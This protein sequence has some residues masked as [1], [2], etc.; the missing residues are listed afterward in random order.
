M[1]GGA[2][3]PASDIPGGERP[4]DGPRRGTTVDDVR[5]HNLSTVLGIVHRDGPTSRSRLTRIIGLNRSTI[6]AL[7][8]ELVELGLVHEAQPEASKTAGRPSPV[9]VASSDVVAFA[10]NPEV[11]AITVAKVGLNGELLESSRVLTGGIP[12]AER[13]VAISTAE[14]DRMRAAM[15]RGSRVVGVGVAMPGLVRHDDGLVR[16]A[17]HLG[18]HDEPFSAKLSDAV[19]LVVTTGNDA[20]LGAIAESMFGAGQGVGDIV[21]LTGGASGI[22]SGV[23]IGGH[24]LRGLSGYAGELGHCLVNSAGIR[25]HCG[26]IGCLETEVDQSRLLDA[27]G[28]S[29]ADPEE[30]DRLL[31]E[32]TS[33]RVAAEIERQ[34]G[35]LAVAVRN[36]VNSFNPRLVVLDGFLGSLL[37]AASL[38][39]P[40]ALASDALPVAAESVR[41]VRA[42]LRGRSLMIGAAELAF[43]GLL[44]DPA[45]MP[46]LRGG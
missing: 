8:S 7:V 37:D 3:G 14:V 41:V 12:S 36:A 9:V 25:C 33:E 5:R 17:P 45:G 29:S 28:V 42:R 34:L 21:Y 30:L 32:S 18:W 4:A 40:E 20:S 13:A 19:G 10:V 31:A 44:T 1:S 23:L 26:A 27:L 35:F 15:P 24:L 43:G 2:V 46:E 38:E 11:D 39:A 6:A 22:G 16:L